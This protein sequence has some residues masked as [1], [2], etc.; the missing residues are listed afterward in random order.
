AMELERYGVTVNAIAPGGRTRMT[1]QLFAEAMQTEAAGSF[2]P[3][4]PENSAPVVAW[5]ASV[6]SA[7]VT[8]QVIEA[9]GGRIAI[10]EGWCPGPTVEAGRRWDPA[11]V[12]PIIRDLL[13]RARPRGSMVP[14]Q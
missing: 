12:G 9:W 5:L 6:D 2:D 13:R 8:G 3:F 10:V 14:A 7:G 1:E 11:E 4:D